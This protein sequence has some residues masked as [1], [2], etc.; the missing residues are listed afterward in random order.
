MLTTEEIAEEY[1]RIAR[2]EPTERYEAEVVLR[3]HIEAYRWSNVA[4][5]R[6]RDREAHEARIA[7]DRSVVAANEDCV[8]H[9]RLYLEAL[10]C[11]TKALESIAEAIR[12]R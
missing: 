11:N 3:L 6:D 1:E 2:L 9:R 4:A 12:S 10:D 7:A 5:E 8:E